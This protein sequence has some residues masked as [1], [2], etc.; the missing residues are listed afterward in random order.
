MLAAH[1]DYTQISERSGSLRIQ[2]EHGAKGMFRCCEVAAPQ[3]L[4]S[5]LKELLLLRIQL[6]GI[7]CIGMYLRSPGRQ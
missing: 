3:S 6:G 4:F 2:R 5:R 1:L 7:R